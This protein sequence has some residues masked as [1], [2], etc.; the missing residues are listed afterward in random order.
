MEFKK[1]GIATLV[2]MGMAFSL[3][4]QAFS[5]DLDNEASADTLAFSLFDQGIS[6]FN[7]NFT[8]ND[9]QSGTYVDNNTFL[10][11][12]GIG[13][14]VVLSTGSTVDAVDLSNNRFFASTSFGNP[15]SDFLSE[16][17]G[18]P[19]FDAATLSFDF[20]FDNNIG[21]NIEFAL[22]FGSEEYR[23]FPPF[24][25]NDIFSFSI[26]GVN[27][28]QFSNGDN[29]STASINRNSRARSFIDNG[30]PATVLPTE[31]NGLTQILTFDVNGLDAGVHT[32]EFR[33]ADG[34]DDRGDSF[35]FFT[36]FVTDPEPVQVPELSARGASLAI[37]FLI[38]I[39]LLMSENKK[40]GGLRLRN[41]LA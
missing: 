19:T 31:A 33:I 23:D 14:G 38:S 34:F 10:T 16:T 20:Q 30:E 9:L 5:I 28:S 39:L 11:D 27:Q 41:Q 8:G 13:S 2:T 32:A 3:N 24:R 6:T 25:Q 17:I 40:A 4:T 37:I 12:F 36:A 7:A 1:L 18:E 26:D 22:I 15:G 21:G 29:I 35:A